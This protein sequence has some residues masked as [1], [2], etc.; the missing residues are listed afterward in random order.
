M[1]VL[2]THTHIMQ[3]YINVFTQAYIFIYIQNIHTYI[4]VYIHKIYITYTCI[5]LIYANGKIFS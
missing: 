2:Y 4:H 3:I 1:W 5:L